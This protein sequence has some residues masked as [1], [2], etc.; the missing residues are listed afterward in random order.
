MPGHYE[1]F[2]KA[3]AR[4]HEC[5]FEQRSVVAIPNCLVR[6]RGGGLVKRSAGRPAPFESCVIRPRDHRDELTIGKD[7][8]ARWNFGN[9]QRRRLSR[10]YTCEVKE[11]EGRANDDLVSRS[12][13]I[14]NR[15][16]S[17]AEDVPSTW[18]TKWVETGH[19]SRDGEA[20]SGDAGTGGGA[21]RHRPLRGPALQ[22][23]EAGAKTEVT[24]REGQC[25]Q[26]LEKS[27]MFALRPLEKLI[28]IESVITRKADIDLMSDRLDEACAPPAP[29]KLGLSSKDDVKRR[30]T[31]DAGE[32]VVAGLDTRRG[33]VQL[34]GVDVAKI[35]QEGPIAG[36]GHFQRHRREW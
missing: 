22:V 6:S 31:C 33:G 4:S 11:V 15:E 21:T 9:I 23:G 34:G 1:W 18:G 16:R 24:R 29:L 5:T 14:G 26:S 25:R 10:R 32:H 2:P 28:E 17:A 8:D 35:D 3:Q 30:M 20:A 12:E 27:V 19:G 36:M 13:A 7:L